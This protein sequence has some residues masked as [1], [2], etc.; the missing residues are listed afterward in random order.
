MLDAAITAGS[1]TA[2]GIG[3]VTATAAVAG[4]VTLVVAVP[5]GGYLQGKGRMY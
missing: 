3:S 4:A 5:L 1:A 2:R